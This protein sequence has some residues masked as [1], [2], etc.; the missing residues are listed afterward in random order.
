[1]IRRAPKQV[2]KKQTAVSIRKLTNSL[3]DEKSAEPY[4]VINEEEE[5]ERDE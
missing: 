3:F 4:K 1:M 5:K 2:Q